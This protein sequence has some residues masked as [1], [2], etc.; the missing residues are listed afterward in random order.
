MFNEDFNIIEYAIGSVYDR[1]IWEKPHIDENSKDCYES[2]FR[3]SDEIKKY[4]S[5]HR[6]PKTKKQSVSGY[7]GVVWADKLIL[8]IDREGDLE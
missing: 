7:E 2:V 5:E 3:H 6:D 4:A 8:D 1:H